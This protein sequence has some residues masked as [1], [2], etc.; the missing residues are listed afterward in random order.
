MLTLM[1][2]GSGATTLAGGNGGG[3]VDTR[4]RSQLDISVLIKV[5]K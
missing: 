4:K 5:L 1:A 2:P 3:S